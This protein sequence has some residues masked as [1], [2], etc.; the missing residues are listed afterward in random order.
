MNKITKLMKSA[1]HSGAVEKGK[2]LK[3]NITRAEIESLL[4]Y[5]GDKHSVCINIQMTGIG[6]IITVDKNYD[7]NNPTDITD[8]GSF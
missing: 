8:Y 2:S 1:T 3:T 7:M 4:E 6:S 5:C